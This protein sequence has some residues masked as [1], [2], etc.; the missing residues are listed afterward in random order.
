VPKEITKRRGLIFDPIYINN[1]NSPPPLI[2]LPGPV[3]K[4]EWPPDY[5]CIA[6]TDS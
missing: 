4:S 5:L 6:R 2:I 3:L 1:F